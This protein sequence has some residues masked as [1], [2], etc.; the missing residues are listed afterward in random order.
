MSIVD[1]LINNEHRI[2]YEKDSIC[3]AINDTDT[4]LLV[5]EKYNNIIRMYR[6]CDNCLRCPGGRYKATVDCYRT[7]DV[8][9]YDCEL[10]FVVI[11]MLLWGKSF[12]Q[13]T[14]NTL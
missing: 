8:V 6:E 14:N 13:K 2:K 10:L 12:V 4:E 11:V 1:H 7:Y 9:K 3:V 5:V